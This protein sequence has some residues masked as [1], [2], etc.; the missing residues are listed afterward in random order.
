M[1][2]RPTMFVG[3][4]SDSKSTADKIAEKLRRKVKIRSW[5]DVFGLGELNLEA[6][7]REAA[8]CDFALFVWGVDDYTVGGSGIPRDNVVYEAGLFAG[9]LGRHRVFVA[10]A[11]NTKIPSDY[12][13][14]TTAAYDP[15][16]ADVDAVARQIRDRIKLLGPKPVAR[17]VGF[18]WQLVVT[19]RER[20]VVSFVEIRPEHGGRSVTMGG[21]AWD[22]GSR[23][24]TRWD[25]T[26]TQFNEQTETLHY[27][28]EGTSL[29]KRGAPQTFGVGTIRYGKS[30]ITGEYSSTHRNPNGEKTDFSSTF[31]LPATTEDE[32]I[33]R[34]DD[35]D[36]WAPLV[37]RILEMRHAF[38]GQAD[39]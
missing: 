20:S 11:K 23:L 27:A 35:P 26:S 6:L 32:A 10:H 24:V 5:S 16:N 15:E 1:T 14:V 31:Y 19:D 33:M 29:L 38:R 22:P 28:W 2:T 9:A 12:L 34:G 4:S 18:W 21:H 30:P 8:A 25:T 39:R 37:E 3:S 7:L 17:L 13:G 36:A